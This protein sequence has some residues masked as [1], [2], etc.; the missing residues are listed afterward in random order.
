MILVELNVKTQQ[1][2]V[3]FCKFH[4]SYAVF[5][6]IEDTYFSHDYYKEE[7]VYFQDSDNVTLKFVVNTARKPAE[8]F[9]YVVKLNEVCYYFWIILLFLLFVQI[10]KSEI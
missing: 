9:F 4:F 1:S 2:T 6:F 5:G 10:F 3:L 7:D 8:E